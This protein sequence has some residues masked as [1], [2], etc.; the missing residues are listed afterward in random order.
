MRSAQLV[1][2]LLVVN[3]TNKLARHSPQGN[4][5]EGETLVGLVQLE[6]Q[7]ARED[8]QAAL[9]SLRLLTGHLLLGSPHGPKAQCPA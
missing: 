4:S 9:H 6:C 7:E 8:P 5:C 1:D 3:H 2:G